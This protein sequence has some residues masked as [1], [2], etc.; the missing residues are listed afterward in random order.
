MFALLRLQAALLPLFASLHTGHGH[1]QCPLECVGTFVVPSDRGVRVISGP[2]AKKVGKIIKDLTETRPS[3]PDDEITIAG[4]KVPVP[5]KVKS[6]MRNALN[7]FPELSPVFLDILRNRGPISSPVGKQRFSSSGSQEEPVT[8]VRNPEQTVGPDAPL[9]RLPDHFRPS[10]PRPFEKPI[11]PDTFGRLVPGQRKPRNNPQA[12][13]SPEFFVPKPFDP[14]TSGP[15]N[16]QSSRSKG[17]L[18]SKFFGPKRSKPQFFGQPEEQIPSDIESSESEEFEPTRPTEKFPRSKKTEPN[19]NGAQKSSLP[20]TSDES[21]PE[22]SL[23]SGPQNDFPLSSKNFKPDSSSEPEDGMP[24]DNEPLG[25]S[26]SSPQNDFPFS[27]KTLKPDS[28][29]EP[30]ESTPGDNKPFGPSESEES[31]NPDSF[32]PEGSSE[33]S[34]SGG[35]NPTFSKSSLLPSHPAKTADSK[36]SRP[37]GFPPSSQSERQP[38]RPTDELSTPEANE[39]TPEVSLPDLVNVPPKDKRIPED[40]RS[41]LKFLEDNPSLFVPVYKILVNKGVRFPDLRRPFDHVTINGKR[42]NLPRPITAAFT[43][44]INDQTFTLPR[45]ADKLATFASQHPEQLPAITTA[46]RQLGGTL[47]PDN[48]GRVSSFTLF[49]KKT[50]LPHSV[51]PR[52]VVNG[53][54][55]TLP[56]DMEELV[57]TIE[58]RPQL[59]HKIL[60]I[61]ETFG[62]R[63]QRSPSGEIRSIEFR[64]RNFPVRSVTPVPVFIRGRRYNIP[65]DLERILAQ[66][67]SQV[68]GELISALQRSKVPV[69]VDN[70]TGNVVG[71][72][73]DGVRIPFPV[74]IRLGI[75]LGGRHFLIPRDLP[76]IVT[77]LERHGVPTDVLNVLYNNYGIIPVRGPDHDVTAIEFNGKRY[78]IKPQPKTSI[79]VGGHRLMLPRDNRKLV[80]LFQERK[81]P[82]DQLLRTIQNAGYRLVPGPNGVLQTAHKGYDVIKLPVGIRMLLSINGVKYRI[83]QDIPHIVELLRTIRNEAAVEKILDNLKTFGVDVRKGPG[84]VTLSFNG[85]KQTFPLNQE[86]TFNRPG[87]GGISGSVVSVNFNGRWYRLPKDAK[88]LV[89]AVRASGPEVIALLV[90]TLQS[91]GVKVNLTP[92]GDDIVSFVIQGRV[93]PVPSNGG[94]IGHQRTSP[95]GHAHG[96]DEDSPNR[97]RVAIRGREFV[98]P[99]DIGRLPKLLPGF[100]Y[101]ELITA[102]HRAGHKLEVDDQG[103]FYGMRVHGGRLV[104]F[105]VRFSVSVFAD[106]K[107]RPYRVP[108]ELEQL[109]RVLPLHRWNWNAVR[110]TLENAGIEIRGGNGG[111]PHLIGFQGQFY[112]VAKSHGGAGY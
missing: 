48:T 99:D 4:E 111:A 6:Q 42:V 13:G 10:E 29:S 94:N 108:K 24:V 58:K 45:D 103:M 34:S 28:S 7:T 112:K 96:S 57:R 14:D 64:G 35:S 98:I 71:I 32:S 97:F 38:S 31:S 16:D 53:R 67:D 30:E 68:V 33:P 15:S 63:P 59:F 19:P 61:L 55:F 89:T 17:P 82:L 81:I 101:G 49:D 60:P 23:P 21:S 84:Q 109:A 100:Q 75:K 72:E 40:V 54:R 9:A 69:V 87:T 51:T 3:S 92:S 77:Q 47:T 37:S 90:K 65:A 62:A 76:S 66:P 104:N 107:G 2:A 50:G 52:I 93:I 5:S 102:L 70:D 95:A 56:N 88:D 80:R 73:R 8:P 22:D 18:D 46:I 106:R 25:P 43:V 86:H 91:N 41:Y 110:K 27:S 79:E 83:P 26:E 78:P 44:R 1:F 20:D 85:E 105:P 74:T 39:K 11:G 36:F 12:S